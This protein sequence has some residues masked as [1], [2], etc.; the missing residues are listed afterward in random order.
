MGCVMRAIVVPTK[1]VLRL[2]CW[3]TRTIGDADA[4]GGCRLVVGEHSP[5]DRGAPI[6]DKGWQFAPPARFY[7][8][9]RLPITGECFD[10]QMRGDR[11][12]TRHVTTH[13]ATHL[14]T[15]LPNLG[16]DAAKQEVFV[17]DYDCRQA[18]GT[19][20]GC[21]HG[22]HRERCCQDE[23]LQSVRLRVSKGYRANCCAE[24][25][26]RFHFGAHE[27]VELLGAKAW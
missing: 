13:P 14:Y 25:T 22:R 8:S 1:L 11:P 15:S 2:R 24:L 20:V 4:D 9:Q 10:V 26:G 5:K 27:I 6:P 3:M 16:A 18:R 17:L 12:V 21:R 7:R 19:R 23:Y